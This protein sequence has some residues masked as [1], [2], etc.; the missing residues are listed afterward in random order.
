MVTRLA[1]NREPSLIPT[2]PEPGA[3]RQLCPFQ[4]HLFC[5]ANQCLDVASLVRRFDPRH[6][7]LPVI[8]GFLCG[9][10][11][12]VLEQVLYVRAGPVPILATA[13]LI[14]VLAYV[15]RRPNT[16][17]RRGIVLLGW[18]FVG[19][20]VALLG[21][22]FYALS[23]EL[24]RSMTEPEMIVYDLGLFLWFVG[25]LTAA[26]AV[27]ARVNDR[28]RHLATVVLLGPVLQL[29]WILLVTLFVYS[30]L[31]ASVTHD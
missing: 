7:S 15:H 24:P 5:R 13:P 25:S 16:G 23:F 21:V 18:G 20:G 29:G 26:Y 14:A 27:A 30:G 12:H 11:F 4:P 22:I 1:V 31:Y 3:N 9:L 28:T 6:S 2:L 19:S 8:V 17:I 10:G